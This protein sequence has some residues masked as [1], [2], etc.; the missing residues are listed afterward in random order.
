MTTAL[1]PK[2]NPEDL[3]K[4][5]RIIAS[6]VILSREDKILMGRKDLLKG[7]VYPAVWHIPGGGVNRDESLEDAA[8]REGLEEV[9][10]DFISEKLTPLPFIGR[11]ESVKTLPT[12]EKVWCTMI[13]NRFE[14]RLDKPASQAEVS[15]G[16]DLIELRWFS[17]NELAEVNQ[18]PGG[19]EFFIQA[20]YVQKE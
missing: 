2:R 7:G 3:R 8:R 19:K 13:F 18:V 16:D 15:P 6:L 4:V 9:G 17:S 20:G 14:V 5:K 10:I 12:G 1:Y 11:G